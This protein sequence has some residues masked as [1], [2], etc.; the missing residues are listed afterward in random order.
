VHLSKHL[1]LS[2]KSACNIDSCYAVNLVD[3]DSMPVY[4]LRWDHA[5]LTLYRNA[6]GCYLP[7]IL[8]ELSFLENNENVNAKLIEGVYRWL[9]EVLSFC[10]ENTIPLQKK[11]FLKF[12]WDQ[13]LDALKDQ[14]I[15]SCNT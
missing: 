13:E 12:W 11:H 4:S 14:S 2:V 7:F 3:S 1:P 5:D 6:T 15:S 8:Q 10:S 9:V